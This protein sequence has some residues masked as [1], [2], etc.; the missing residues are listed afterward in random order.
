MRG[1]ERYDARL[2]FCVGW[3][4]EYYRKMEFGFWGK[5]KKP[6]FALAPMANVTDAAFRYIIAKYGKFTRP[7][8]TVGGGP[9]VMWTE[10]VSCD[11]LCSEGREALL[12]DLRF[13]ASERPIVAQFFGAV[14]EHF[15]E[16]AKL[17]VEL[18][19]DGIDIN[20]G[21]PDKNVLK[22]G[23][24]AACID[25]PER[26]KEIIRATQE[27]AGVLPVSVK[28]RIGTK[29]NTLAA[30]LPLL[31]AQDLAAITI[32]ARTAKELSLV[33]AHWE[34]F[35][36]AVRIRNEVQSG[37]AKK[38]L[39]L[40]NGDVE[41][42]EDAAKKAEEYGLDGVMIGRGI[43]GNPWFFRDADMFRTAGLAYREKS[44]LQGACLPK[45]ASPSPHTYFV[46]VGASFPHSS[47]HTK[48]APHK[49]R[50]EEGLH[51]E[52]DGVGADEKLRVMVEHTFLFEEMFR[53]KKSFDVMKKHY[54][55][56][57][58]G[59]KGAKELRIRL[60][61][62]KNAQEVADIVENVHAWHTHRSGAP[63][64]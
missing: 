30:W 17:A 39:L 60:M 11:G 22:Q 24:G 9:D 62:T 14:P 55:A 64:R 42:I 26:A 45:Q 5:L 18:G 1:G 47:Q 36:D 8:G 12:Q 54:K 29:R 34:I 33:P 48:P 50:E 23:A 41:S 28:T 53:G 15:Y 38:T 46:G 61:D 58:N 27:G 35:H 52:S 43:F 49:F 56:Y 63:G 37:S 31:L 10:F 25:A 6:I 32:H 7:D 13:D 40:G 51:K 59:F 3:T 44:A 4:V 20:M 19:F 2:S 21:C 57:V 16:C